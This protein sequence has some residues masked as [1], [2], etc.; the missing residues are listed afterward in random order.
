MVGSP[1]TWFRWLLG[2]C[3]W[4]H[5]IGERTCVGPREVRETLQQL[6]G[7]NLVNCLFGRYS[8]RE[9]ALPFAKAQIA[10]AKKKLAGNK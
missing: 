8:L 10:A 5:H 4:H 7:E 9:P 1:R 3:A 2:P 6:E